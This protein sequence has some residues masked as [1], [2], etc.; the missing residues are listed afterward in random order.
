MQVLDRK[1]KVSL[2]ALKI[3]QWVHSPGL[4]GFVGRA[5]SR[6]KLMGTRAKQNRVAVQITKLD[7]NEKEV[8]SL[9]FFK[10]H[11]WVYA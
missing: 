3:L 4:K 5:T 10:D 7:Q 8:D 11:H 1:K 2:H 6:K 9:K